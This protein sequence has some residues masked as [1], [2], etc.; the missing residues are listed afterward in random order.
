MKKSKLKQD[1]CPYTLYR[2]GI[3]EMN[4]NNKEYLL[5]NGLGKDLS[6]V[7]ST[8]FDNSFVFLFL[9]DCCIIS[10]IRLQKSEL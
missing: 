3:L 1:E 7:Y 8:D 6:R 5:S 4:L 9:A 2:R 10:I